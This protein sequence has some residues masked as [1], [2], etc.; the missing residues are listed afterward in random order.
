MP[1]APKPM[2]PALRCA[3]V[4]DE[5]LAV[6]L[7]TN[8]VARLPNLELTGTATNAL[9]AFGLLQ[10][11]AVDLLFLDIQMPRLTGIDFLKTLTR[12]PLVIMTTA[13]RQFALDGYELDVVDFLLKPILFERFMKAVGKAFQRQLPDSPEPASLPDSVAQAHLYIRVDREMVKVLLADIVWIESLKDYVRICTAHTQFVT[14]MRI[15]SLEEK[16]PPDQFFRI[17]RSF[18]VAKNRITAFSSPGRSAE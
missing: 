16:L 4:D 17:H 7:L 11:N 6:E 2:M 14:Y 5:P 15:S 10:H 9:E 18:I 3:V 13:Y 12:P 1:D 8:Y